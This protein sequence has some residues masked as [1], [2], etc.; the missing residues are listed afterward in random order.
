MENVLKAN[1]QDVC[2]VKDLQ[3]ARG[4]GTLELRG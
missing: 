2:Q 4:E 1:P 3:E